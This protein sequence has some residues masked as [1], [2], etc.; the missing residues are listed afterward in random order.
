MAGHLHHEAKHSYSK[1]AWYFAL[2]GFLV[3]SSLL[4]PLAVHR[5]ARLQFDNVHPLQLPHQL[6]QQVQAIPRW[7]LTLDGLDCGNHATDDCSARQRQVIRLALQAA[8]VEPLYWRTWAI[9][10]QSWPPQYGLWN[11]VE[12]SRDTLAAN[13]IS[14][15]ERPTGSKKATGQWVVITTRRKPTSHI[16]SW[17][18]MPD[19]NVVVVSISCPKLALV[20]RKWSLQLLALLSSV[21]GNLVELWTLKRWQSSSHLHAC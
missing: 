21:H 7:N 4:L 1:I 17:A 11:L 5:A 12:P 10:M 13:L 20:P 8:A 15:V 6:Q 2:V 16:A 9:D 14:L 18:E 19:W 3:T